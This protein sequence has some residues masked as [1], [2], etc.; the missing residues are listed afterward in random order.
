MNQPELF[1]PGDFV[2]ISWLVTGE[3]TVGKIETV[4]NFRHFTPHYFVRTRSGY[5]FWYRGSLIRRIAR[6]R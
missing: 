6:R 5:G 4:R 2:K 1:H 3:V